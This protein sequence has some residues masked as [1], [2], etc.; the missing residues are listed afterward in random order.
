[1]AGMM[2]NMP[3]NGPAG[4]MPQMPNQMFGNLGQYPNMNSNNNGMI[5]NNHGN[6]GTF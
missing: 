5:M 4:A 3:M 1:M 6:Q 2:P